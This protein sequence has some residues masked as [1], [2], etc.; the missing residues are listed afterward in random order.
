MVMEGVTVNE[1]FTIMLF[2][3]AEEIALQEEGFV[4]SQFTI[5]PFARVLIEIVG[6]FVPTLFPLI[7]H[8][9]EGAL[10][11]LEGVAVKVTDVPGHMFP[12]TEDVIFTPGTTEGLMD[13]IITLE[14]AVGILIHEELLVTVQLT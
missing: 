6:L 4:N 5:S 9:Y 10:P 1:T 7:F 12:V 2:E 8:W 14:F 13:A 3:I 11:P